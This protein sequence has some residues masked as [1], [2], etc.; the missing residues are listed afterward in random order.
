MYLLVCILIYRFMFVL[1]L[2]VIIIDLT[3]IISPVMCYVLFVIDLPFIP[4]LLPYVISHV[5]LFPYSLFFTTIHYLVLGSIYYQLLP[6]I[7]YYL[8]FIYYCF[9]TCRYLLRITYSLSSSI[10]CSILL[11]LAICS[12]SSSK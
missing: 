7:I 9:L 1:N 12:S 6:S 11:V 5:L 8:S 4:L 2:S 3:R 10:M